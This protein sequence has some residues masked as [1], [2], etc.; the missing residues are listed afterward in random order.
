MA[1]KVLPWPAVHVYGWSL[2][3]RWIQGNRSTVLV[4]S[5]MVVPLFIE[6][7]RTVYGEEID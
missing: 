7:P 6:L 2:S 3:G 4:I 1:K 5:E